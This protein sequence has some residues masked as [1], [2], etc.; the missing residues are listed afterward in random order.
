M[1]ARSGSSEL[2]NAYVRSSLLKGAAMAAKMAEHPNR[3]MIRS[4]VGDTLA[5]DSYVGADQYHPKIWE[6]W[7]RERGPTLFIVV[8]CTVS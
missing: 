8:E 6:F 7:F 1:M 2:N 5:D 3:S 4:S